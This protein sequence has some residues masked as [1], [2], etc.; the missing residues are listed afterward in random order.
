MT[1][2]LE[3]EGSYPAIGCHQGQY[4]QHFIF[5]VTYEWAHHARLL[6]FNKLEK[7]VRD[8]HSSLLDPFVS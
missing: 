1:A 5:F 8:M 6:H 7:L 4:S 2:D 3:I